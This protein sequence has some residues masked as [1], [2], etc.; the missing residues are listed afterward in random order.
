MIFEEE[1]FQQQ[2]LMRLPPELVE[3]ASGLAVCQDILATDLG[4]FPEA[5]RHVVHRPQGCSQHILILCVSGEGWCRINGHRRRR[6]PAG[7]IVLIPEGTPHSYG[8]FVQ[9]PWRLYWVHFTG[10]RASTYLELLDADSDGSPKNVSGLTDICE[11][12]ETLWQV[13]EEGGS[14]PGLMR[15]SAELSRL[16][17]MIHGHLRTGNAS[18]GTEERIQRVVVQMREGVATRYRLQDFAQSAGVSTPHFCALFKA[19]TGVAPMTY[20]S[21]LRMRV[22]AE[23]LEGSSETI[24]KIALNVGYQNPFHFTRAFR[25]AH[26][27]SPRDYRKQVR[28]VITSEEN[29][30]S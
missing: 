8:A 12:F 9:N 23:W 13:R 26:G 17:V 14:E 5:A 4:H 18:L 16:L 10:E 30:E 27:C 15:M 6:I 1:G 2:R 29:D 22:A 7:H 24:S 19:Q 11:A 25:R 3:R 20:F 21:R 28:G